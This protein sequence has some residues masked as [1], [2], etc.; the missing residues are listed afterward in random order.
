MNLIHTATILLF[1]ICFYGLITSKQM[2]KSVVF[3]VLL[4][5]SVIMFFLS[6]G[7][8]SGIVP[9]I[10]DYLDQLEYVA[11]PLPQA[12]MITASVVGVAVATINITMLM[13]LFRDYKTTDWDMA[14]KK[15]M[16]E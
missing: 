8:Q 13:S 2:I 4:Q 9:P 15:S 6:L 12:L 7:F 10:G 5:A 14:Q 3:L 11:D 1:F 16:V